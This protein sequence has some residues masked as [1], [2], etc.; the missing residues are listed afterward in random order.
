M[1][2]TTLEV[3][4]LV[5]DGVHSDSSLAGLSVSDDQL[6]LASADGHETV[7]GLK[8]SL[9]RFVHAL[10]G[11]NSGSLDFHTVSLVTFHGAM[12]IDGITKSIKHAT[13]H[14]FADRHVDDGTGT[15]HDVA[16]L[17]FTIVTKNDDTD[18]VGFQ[19]E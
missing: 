5:Q 18:I 3:L 12:A 4:S 13:Q 1:N 17:N 6:T 9:H 2:L 11:D 10:A 14:L 19:V 15:A 16:F 7:D 8:A